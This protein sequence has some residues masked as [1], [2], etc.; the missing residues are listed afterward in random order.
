MNSN[1]EQQFH[2]QIR[3]YNH[4]LKNVYDQRIALAKDLNIKKLSKI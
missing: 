2:N 4:E 3:G 1:A